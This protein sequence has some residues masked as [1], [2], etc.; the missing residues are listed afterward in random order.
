MVNDKKEN[1]IEWL[2]SIWQEC[3]RVAK[4]GRFLIYTN[5]I[6][7]IPTGMNPPKPW[8]YFHLACWNKPLSLR[9]SFYGICPHWE[10]IF[11]SLKGVKP[12][13]PYRNEEIFSDVID[14][15]VTYLYTKWKGYREKLHPTVKPLYLYQRLVDFGFPKDG[16]VIDPFL[17]SGVTA[18]ACKIMG[19][20]CIG[21]EINEKY[22]EI[23]ANRCRQTVMGLG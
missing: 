13:R 3:G 15:N 6:F 14:A 7:F 17:G 1:Y 20:K 16:V 10:P 22:C 19:R 8:H 2:N 11:I 9:P 21:I 5:T 23:A 18:L 4:D 12:W